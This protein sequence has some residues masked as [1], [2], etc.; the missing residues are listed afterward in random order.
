MDV[1]WGDGLVVPD[2][3]ICICAGDVAN[4]ISES[5]AYLRRFIEPRMP[6][7]YILGNHDYYG[8]GIDFA[9]ERARRL[10]EG[11]QI[12]LLENQS[13]TLGDCR[14]VGATLWTDFAVL[15]G[16]TSTFPTRSGGRRL[17]AL[18]PHV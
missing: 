15:V 7:L 11:T 17:S 5:V 2:A 9:I 3:D 6:V 12:H 14:L 4:S 10:I 18:S 1:F 8:S 16:A 13:V